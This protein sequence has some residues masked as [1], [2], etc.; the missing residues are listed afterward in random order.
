M[1]FELIELLKDLDSIQ[2]LYVDLDV[3]QNGWTTDNARLC[4]DIYGVTAECM[5]YDFPDEAKKLLM[6]IYFNNLPY[7]R[8][9]HN[10]AKLKDEEFLLPPWERVELIKSKL[11]KI[12]KGEC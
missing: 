10:G 4:L 7:A 11:V 12:G 1:D 3:T 5:D 8:A 6:D 9:L 2:F